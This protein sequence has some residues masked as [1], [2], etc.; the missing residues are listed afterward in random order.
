LSLASLV[1][2]KFL[3]K[4]LLDLENK[5]NTKGLVESGK[6]DKFEYYTI[7][8]FYYKR[9]FLI[10]FRQCLSSFHSLRVLFNDFQ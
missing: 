2:G 10:T 9:V 5:K 1:S 4:E 3:K 8:T 7:N 6:V